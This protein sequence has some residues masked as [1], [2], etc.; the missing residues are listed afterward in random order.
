M[1][2]GN[3]EYARHN[4]SYGLTTLL[5]EHIELAGTRLR[6]SF[7]GKSGKVFD[8]GFSDRRVAAV[9]RRLEGLPRQHLFQFLDERG[10]PQRITSDDVNTYIREATGGDFTAKDFRTWA[11]TVLAVRALLEEDADGE[12]NAK[13]SV[14]RAV[15]QVAARLGNTPAVCRSSYIHPEVFA[16]YMDGSLAA[17][18]ARLADTDD[19]V[20]GMFSSELPVL[21]FLKR[22]AERREA[23][24]PLRP[25]KES[26]RQSVA[27]QA[28]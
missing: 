10:E 13:S 25:L 2:V 16:S 27:V 21:R 18:T 26:L 17:L 22:R 9:L 6:F 1:R 4:H 20:P 7:R 3:E 12:S 28:S 8:A 15:K 14:R 24:R 11:A 5:N 19:D 23:R